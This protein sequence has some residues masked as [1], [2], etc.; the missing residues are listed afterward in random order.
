MGIRN[1]DL[2]DFAAFQICFDHQ[3]VSGS[4]CEPANMTGNDG[5]INLDDLALFAATLG[6]P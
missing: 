3:I 5:T 2:A 6:G 1:V 4:D